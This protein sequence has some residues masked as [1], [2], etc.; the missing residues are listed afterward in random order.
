MRLPRDLSKDLSSYG[1]TEVQAKIY[2]ANLATSAASPS[3]IAKQA[4]MNRSEAYRVLRQLKEIGVVTEHGG[5]P[6]RFRPKPPRQVLNLLLQARTKEVEHLRE[7]LP[8]LTR[9]LESIALETKVK[10]SILLVDDDE[11]IRKALSTFLKAS[12]EVHVSKDGND[13][14][15]KAQR[16]AYDAALID[17]RL[18]DINGIELAK[19]LRNI[20]PETKTILITGYASIENAIR[21]I[22]ERVDGYVTKPIDPTELISLLKRKL[23]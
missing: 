5:R 19:S 9:W 1:L 20:N 2:C 6:I 7:N 15:K 4:G 17:I 10:P 13:A 23:Q 22:D 16:R 12:F 21:A 8:R 18:T 14:L 11:R 3:V